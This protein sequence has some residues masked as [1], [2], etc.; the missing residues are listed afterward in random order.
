MRS[1]PKKTD[2]L[3][4]VRVGAADREI[5]ERISEK[6]GQPM[7]RI[8]HEAIRDHIVKV[9]AKMAQIEAARR[10]TLR[11]A[12]APVGFGH[13]KP[14]ASPPPP[15]VVDEDDA[16][17]ESGEVDLNYFADYIAAAKSKADRESREDAVADMIV[18]ASSSREEAEQTVRSLEA[19]LK[20][21]Q[22]RDK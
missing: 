4:R 18:K 10:G 17:D 15:P 1:V 13:Q 2:P 16:R 19:L 12:P 14:K 7:T 22:K 5:L 6:F 20:S 3:I 21:R 9:E 11:G 8:V